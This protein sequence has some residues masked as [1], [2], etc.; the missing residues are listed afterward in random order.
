MKTKLHLVLTHHWYDET[1]S[2]RKRIEYRKITP[3]WARLIW[4]R[5]SEIAFVRFARGYTAT[6]AT[7]RVT[8]ID[9]GPCPIQ[10]WDGDYYRIHFTDIL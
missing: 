3:R 2:G 4:E 9:V 1:T 10:G 6:T 8:Q 7:Y 5:R